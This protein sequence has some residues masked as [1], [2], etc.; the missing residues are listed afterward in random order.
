MSELRYLKQNKLNFLMVQ[1]ILE[2]VLEIKLKGMP[3][4]AN[5]RRKFINGEKYGFGTKTINNV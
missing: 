4:G 2:N 5:N 1:F 3:D